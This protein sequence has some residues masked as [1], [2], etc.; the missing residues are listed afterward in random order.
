[1]NWYTESITI[2]PDTAVEETREENH[3]Q[4]RTQHQN[5]HYSAKPPARQEL[6]MS[7]PAEY[8]PA[9][10]DVAEDDRWGKR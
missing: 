3:H 2:K 1:M 7:D 6:G 4:H 8:D 9:D 5:S 10:L